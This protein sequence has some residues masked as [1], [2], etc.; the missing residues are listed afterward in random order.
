MEI[1]LTQVTDQVKQAL[2]T[3]HFK[4][5]RL[6]FFTDLQNILIWRKKISNIYMYSVVIL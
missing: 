3:F 4:K 5:K 1:M 6:I 2:N